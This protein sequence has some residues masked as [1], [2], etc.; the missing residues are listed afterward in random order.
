MNANLVKCAVLCGSITAALAQGLNPAA[1]L[2]PPTDTWPTYNGDYTG[3][4]YSPLQQINSSNIKSLTL[5]WA[6][7]ANSPAIKSTPLGS[8]RHPVLHRAGTGVGHR[9]AHRPPGLALPL[10]EVRRRSHRTSRRGDVGQ[11]AV[12]R[13]AR[14]ASGLPGR[15]GRTRTLGYRAG[16]R[17]TRVFRHHGAA[18]GRQSRDR[19]RL[20]GR[21]RYPR[22]SGVR[23]SGDRQAAMALVYRA[24]SP[25]SRA[26]KP[27]PRT[28]TPLRMAAA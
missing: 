8:E 6:F 4:R 5:A 9:R 20:G 13:N 27:G 17:A 11:L 15:E 16:G 14:R 28:A 3:R 2:K 19:G 22:I 23:G 24:A 18:G 26:R 1:L 12:F 10:Q 7:Q 25:A 21:H